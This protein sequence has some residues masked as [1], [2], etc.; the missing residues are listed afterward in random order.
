MAGWV[1]VVANWVWLMVESQG[2]GTDGGRKEKTGGK[3]SEGEK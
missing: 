2:E 3:I 1:G